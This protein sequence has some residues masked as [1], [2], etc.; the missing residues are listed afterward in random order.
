MAA[1]RAHL[2]HMLAGGAPPP[3]PPQTQT[4]VATAVP[5]PPPD[6]QPEAQP[7][8]QGTSG[9]AQPPQPGATAAKPGGARA[10]QFIAGAFAVALAIVLIPKPH[11]GAATNEADTNAAQANAADSNAVN[12]AT[13]SNS[14][15]ATEAT[16][17]FFENFFKPD[18]TTAAETAL[19]GAWIR[20]GGAC[21]DATS[22]IDIS[23][24]GSNLEWS[25]G[26]GGS[27]EE[28]VTSVSDGVLHTHRASSDIDY[29]YSISGQTMTMTSSLGNSSSYDRC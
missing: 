1:A 22:I 20:R 23:F 17:A 5:P 27:S 15:A 8:S 3:P 16:N 29:S 21:S 25:T 6:P 26:G 14:L 4:S 2:D 18:A 12:A 28:A 10:W 24:S 11:V 9:A 13:A 7:A 19:K